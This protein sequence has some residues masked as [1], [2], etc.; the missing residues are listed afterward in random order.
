MVV[1]RPPRPVVV[2]Q[3]LCCLGDPSASDKVKSF[4]LLSFLRSR[5]PPPH[6]SFFVACRFFGLLKVRFSWRTLPMQ[7]RIQ[8]RRQQ[9]GLRASENQHLCFATLPPLTKSS[10]KKSKTENQKAAQITSPTTTFH[11]SSSSLIISIV[12]QIKSN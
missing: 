11:T 10:A 9:R 2:T 4:F 7:R 1:A 12:D 6:H 8:F 3:L 5:P